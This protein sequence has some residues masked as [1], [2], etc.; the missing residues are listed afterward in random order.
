MK[1]LLLPI[2]ICAA[3]SVNA[4][5]VFWSE[6][7]GTGCSQGTAASGYSGSNGAW[8]ATSTGTNDAQAN[9]W[10]I[11]ATEAG[12][13]AGSCGDGCGNTSSLTNQS[14]HVGAN[15]GF[16][17]PD[18]GATYNTGGICSF[19]ICVVTNTRAESP[20]INCTG[21]TGLT[22][23]FNYIE[24]GDGTNDDGSVW[25]YDGTMWA[26]LSNTAKTPMTC[27][28][29]GTWTSF[30]MALPA[31]ADNNPNVKIGFNWTNNDD[32]T[33]TDPSFA[34]DSI[35]LAA[36]TFVGINETMHAEV[37]LINDGNDIVI[38]TAAAFHVQ[39]VRDMLGR[40]V[41]AIINDNRITIEE[42]EGIY[43]IE[44]NVNGSTVFKKVISG[45]K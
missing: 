11:S 19:G 35:R 24:N 12:M 42:Q 36:V 7:F 15:D 39:A 37:S 29:Q 22:L 43:F 44:L 41:K 30:S 3:F 32:A 4:Q 31:S 34:V 27:S 23:M 28:P 33:G 9:K 38:N 40:E 25:Y 5:T 1:K 26:L 2:F 21:R 16:T 10:F 18:A 13:P 20:A 6:S 17:T 8:T 45:R 14:L